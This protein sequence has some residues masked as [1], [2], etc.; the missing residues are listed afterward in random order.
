VQAKAV[1]EHFTIEQIVPF[2]Q[3]I[4]DLHNH[5]VMRYECLARLITVDDIIHLPSEFLSIISRSQSN[6][7]LTQRIAELSSAY[8]LQKSMRWSINMFKTDLRDATLMN[9]MQAL[10][11]QLNTNLAGVELAYDSVKGQPHL[12]QDLIDKLPNVH[13]TIDDVHECED[14]F[15]DIIDTGIHAVKIRGNL[16]TRYARTGKGKSTIENIIAQCKT[17]NCDLVAEHIEDDS[18]FDAVCNLG[19]HYGQGYYLSEPK[20]RMTN[21]KQV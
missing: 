2:F 4:F 14:D 6:A 13:I 16:I 3:P 9:W 17:H 12:L 1:V 5:K 19:I 11:G 20:G 8:C 18:T 15:I 21:L 10:F 7:Q